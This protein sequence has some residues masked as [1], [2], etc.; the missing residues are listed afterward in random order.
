MS[1]LQRGKG[2]ESAETERKREKE[3]EFSSFRLLK[4]FGRRN[5]MSGHHFEISSF[6]FPTV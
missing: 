6:G 3:I 1:L 2:S 4:A 5:S